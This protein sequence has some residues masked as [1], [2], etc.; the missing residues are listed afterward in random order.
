MRQ[1]L[2]LFLLFFFSIFL[3]CEEV[4]PPVNLSGGGTG[5]N[6]GD[7]SNQRIVLMEEFTAVACINCPKGHEIIADL[8]DSFPGRI[9]VVEIHSGDLAEPINDTDPDFRTVDGNDLTNYLGPFPFQPSAS[10]D[11]KLW[12]VAPGDFQRLVDRSFWSTFVKS[13]LDSAAK[14][15]LT[16]EKDYN[17][18]SRELNVILNA[19]FLED[20]SDIVNATILITESGM[21]AAQDDGPVEVIEDYVHKY[22][23]R[24][25]LTNYSGELINASTTTGNTWALSK[26]I[27]LPLEWNADNC[28]IVAFI[29][30][31]V[32][33]Y[34]VL[35][36]VGTPVN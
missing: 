33:N 20:I 32:G 3:A 28:R 23:L 27:T 17:S 7:S 22:V 19:E 18:S 15:K 34:D 12:E 29:A 5:G 30:K 8:L 26:S 9:E 24:D 1:L 31:A 2:Y 11:R 13:E 36:V 10:I 25:I 16:I 14:V 21:V 6:G 35:Q 4:G